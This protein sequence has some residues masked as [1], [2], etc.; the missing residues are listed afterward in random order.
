MQLTPP[1]AA[2]PATPVLRS[3]SAADEAA[4]R[5]IFR[6]TVLLGRPLPF[7]HPDL[8]AYEELCLGW[9]LAEGRAV[10]VEQGGLVRGY[11]LACLD[12]GAHA[13]W[14]RWEGQRWARR[15]ARS[16]VT[17]RLQGDA[18]RFCRLRLRD[19]VEAL[20]LGR[21]S[22]LPAH[23]HLNLD[24]DVRDAGIGHR[25]AGAMDALVEQAGLPGWYGEINVPA[26]GSLDALLRQGVRV[27]GRM[28]NRTFTWL[29]GAA[30]ERVTVER[31]LA[32]R[33]AV[34]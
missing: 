29:L 18:A 23:A 33:T 3:A 19:G 6:G 32:E 31:V 27:A 9:Y 20:Q 24:P 13:R 15:A 14:T 10:V 34:L 17:G 26:G 28:P 7:A 22:S 21:L 1:T 25:L 4:I 2:A 11:L 12:E 30:V 5:R 16:L 8:A